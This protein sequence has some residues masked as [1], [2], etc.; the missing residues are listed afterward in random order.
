MKRLYT[1]VQTRASANSPASASA[2]STTTAAAHGSTATCAL[3]ATK[4]R[5]PPTI[6]PL[7]ILQRQ[8]F[9]KRRSTAPPTRRCGIVRRIM[10]HEDLA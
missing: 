3:P 9:A 1:S 10:S 2:S 8:A 4:Q 5:I 6:A 7:H